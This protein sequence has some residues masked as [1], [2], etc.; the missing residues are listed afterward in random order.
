MKI[1]QKSGVQN[2]DDLA[3][4]D[5]VEKMPSISMRNDHDRRVPHFRA[6]TTPQLY[7]AYPANQVPFE[8][9]AEFFYLSHSVWLTDAFFDVHGKTSTLRFFS[10]G[11]KE[12]FA[13]KNK[14]NEFFDKSILPDFP[15][16]RTLPTRD[17][18]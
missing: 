10:A 18:P 17:L 6:E 15:S 2:T 16:I 1:S 5:L 7:I 3:G 11:R 12:N 8:N 9:F 14:N 4:N 13:L